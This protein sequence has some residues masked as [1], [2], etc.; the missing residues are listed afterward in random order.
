MRGHLTAELA[1]SPD[2]KD[3]AS[4]IEGELSSLIAEI[5]PIRMIEEGLQTKDRS[6]IAN[7]VLQASQLGNMDEVV[8]VIDRSK[9]G[10]MLDQLALDYVTYGKDLNLEKIDQTFADKLRRRPVDR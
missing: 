5:A 6:L 10:A 3:L 1:N 2:L 4:Q 8:K 7:A 9:P